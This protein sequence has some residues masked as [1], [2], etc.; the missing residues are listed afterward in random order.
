MTGCAGRS[1]VNS[2]A[3]TGADCITATNTI[4]ADSFLIIGSPSLVPHTRSRL[5][6]EAYP[7]L[8]RVTSVP[9]R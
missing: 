4:D 5:Y 3:A 8:P 7:T 1:I 9:L 6:L 2:A